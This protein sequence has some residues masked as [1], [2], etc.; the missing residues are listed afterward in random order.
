MTS[1]I[2]ALSNAYHYLSTQ[3]TQAIISWKQ[4]YPEGTVPINVSNKRWLSLGRP[5]YIGTNL[6]SAKRCSPGQPQFCSCCQH[7]EIVSISPL[8]VQRWLRVPHQPYLSL[9]C[10]THPCDKKLLWAECVP[11]LPKFIGWSPNPQGDGIRRWC[12]REV[13]RSSEWNTHEWG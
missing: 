12:L 1:T 2:F 9:L 7:N 10:H 4:R 11:L 13:I 5:L 3:T 6:L 8:K